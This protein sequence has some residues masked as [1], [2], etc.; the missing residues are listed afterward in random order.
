MQVEGGMQVERIQVKAGG[1]QA[2]VEEQFRL[3]IPSQPNFSYSDKSFS[4]PLSL[5]GEE[6]PTNT[7]LMELI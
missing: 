5:E 1:P 4:D 7:H 6:L 2:K 3:V